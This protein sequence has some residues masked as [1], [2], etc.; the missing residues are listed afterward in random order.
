MTTS[1]DRDYWEDRALTHGRLA[2]GYLDPWN[3]TY[4][5]PLRWAAFRRICPIVPGLRVLDVGCGTGRWSVRMADMG[6]QVLGAD[7]S[8]RMIEMAEPHPR[9]EYQVAAAHELDCPDRYFDVVVSVT[10]LQHITDPG[11]LQ[12]ALHNLR[13]MLKDSG[14]FFVLEYSPLRTLPS[15]E[16]TYM[17]YRT[18][19]QWIELM[20]KE[21]FQLRSSTGIRF[22]GRRAY[23]LW[24]R[25]RGARPAPTSSSASSA[26]ATG[27]SGGEAAGSSGGE[28]T[29]LR[30][31]QAMER[32]ISRVAFLR[33]RSDLHA[34]VFVKAASPP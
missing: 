8:A 16:L 27:V 5:Q 23:S 31:T 4:E 24:R 1:P 6:A 18:Q 28:A 22:I 20:A 11:E 26:V 34:Y 25:L 7:I 21:G 29:L 14:R 19:K 13:R 17:R 30:L 32:G 15:Q 9:V 33:Q 3:E 12:R 2:G 10:V